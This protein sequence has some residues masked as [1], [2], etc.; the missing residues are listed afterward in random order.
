MKKLIKILVCFIMIELKSKLSWPLALK[1]IGMVAAGWVLGIGWLSLLIAIR[2]THIQ[3][4]DPLMWP[5]L[6]PVWLICLSLISI[7]MYCLTGFIR[8]NPIRVFATIIVVAVQCLL[9]SA[10]LLFVSCYVHIWAGG[11]L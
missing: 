1:A 4:V 7:G 5:L 8:N 11:S 3:I 10:S 2:A 9:F 6:I